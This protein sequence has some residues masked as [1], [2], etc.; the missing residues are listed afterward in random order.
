M[1]ERDCQ[2]ESRMRHERREI[3]DVKTRITEK[4]LAIENFRNYNFFR[5]RNGLM[6]ISLRHSR[7]T[8]CTIM[9]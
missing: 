3:E 2:C 9:I 8:E 1:R 7:I 6:F 4:R 5:F